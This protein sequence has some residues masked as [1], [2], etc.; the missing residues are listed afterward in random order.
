MRQ[1]IGSQPTNQLPYFLAESL[2]FSDGIRR[3]DYIIAF[4]L[5]EPSIE[6]ELRECFL[7]L[8]RHGV[9]IEIED[10]SGEAPVNFSEEISSHHFVKDKPVFA[11]LHV[12]WNKLL[13]IA[14]L[15]HF[16]KPI[17]I[18]TKI[19]YDSFAI[20]RRTAFKS[21][22][23][24]EPDFFT[25]TE[26]IL[27]MEYILDHCSFEDD[28]SDTTKE[29]AL[30]PKPASIDE[31]RKKGII[32]ALFPLHEPRTHST[33]A[34]LLKEWAS[35]HRIFQIQPLDKIREYF[36]EKVA[37]TFAWIQF[38][39]WSFAII[40][41]VA[42]VSSLIPPFL[43]S[44]PHSI[45]EEVCSNKSAPFILCPTCNGKGC[46]FKKLKS[47]CGDL[48]WTY[49]F[50][51]PASVFIAF[52]APVFGMIYLRL[53][54]YRQSKLEYK[55]HLHNYK[56]ADE[57][58]R[59][60]YLRKIK[61]MNQIFS[62]RSRLSYWTYRIPVLGFTSFTTVVLISLSVALEV[63]TDLISSLME[64]KFSRSEND[65]ISTNAR[66][67]ALGISQVFNGSCVCIL[68]ALYRFWIT[69]STTA[70]CHRTEE[71]HVRSFLIKS[72]FMEFVNMYLSIVTGILV[73]GLNF[74]HPGRDLSLLEPPDWPVWSGLFGIFYEIYIKCTTIVF[75]KSAKEWIPWDKVKKRLPS[76]LGGMATAPSAEKVTPGP[77]ASKSYKFCLE[78]YNLMESK[79]YPI[80]K[81][82]FDMCIFIGFTILFL[83]AS[84]TWVVTLLLLSTL[85]LRGLA[86][87]LTRQL[88][89]ISPL[90]A[91]SIG[92]WMLLLKGITGLSVF[93]NACLIVFASEFVNKVIYQ[94][95]YSP[96]GSMDGY[97][98]FT[99]SYMDVTSFDVSERDKKLLK[100]AQYCR[101]FGYRESPKSSNPYALTSV[102]WHILAAKF[103]FVCVFIVAALL[104]N[105]IINS[106][107]GRHPGSPRSCRQNAVR[108]QPEP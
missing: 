43:K 79:E 105:W 4:K 75:I 68:S 85:T 47:S 29:A 30:L 2:L 50:D 28:N 40:F 6:A 39:L 15:L 95:Y 86:M 46:R 98:N 66:F 96:D 25:P 83:P 45:I 37:F 104:V 76:I 11:K 82:Q 13:Q 27:A 61:Q 1:N 99:L 59:F 26:R 54:M 74:G 78:N 31:L 24:N 108:L 67:I 10:S 84:F 97:V 101:Y 64:D 14:E 36:G 103:I 81:Q 55:W 9:D 106:G 87:K 18:G 49:F 65:F 22:S 93:T 38:S 16:Q 32:L 89:R 57:P 72:S 107:S 91:R 63:L 20:S 70:E 51:S 44:R 58:S 102:Y 73:R 3:I 8:S 92:M 71:Q 35:P 94:M 12:Q 48:K 33:R 42:L 60:Q 23:D 17:K 7:N 5:L 90:R 34:Y 41:V 88:R 80:F 69:W 19:L 56:S 62:K 52:I 77:N 21:F 53:W 100:G